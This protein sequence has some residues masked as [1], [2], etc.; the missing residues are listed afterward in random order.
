V[1]KKANDSGDF[2]LFARKNVNL[3][4][5]YAAYNHTDGGDPKYFGTFPLDTAG[6]TYSS[7]NINVRTW[8]QTA[9]RVMA[10]AGVED[11]S[12]VAAI[13][14]YPTWRTMRGVDKPAD[15]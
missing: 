3:N 12:R 4:D 11:K 10:E 2:W 1:L 14:Y 5:N 7:N 9:Q 8:S 6:V 13:D 15:E